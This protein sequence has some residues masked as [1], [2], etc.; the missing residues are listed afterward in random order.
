MAKF[1]STITLFFAALV[2]FAVL[3]APTMVKAQKLCE[4]RSGTWS[5]NCL[6]NKAWKDKCIGL[7]GA[8]HGSCNIAFPINKC[9]CYYTC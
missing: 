5:G 2:L 8:R 6:N 1:A 9:L 4:K 3:E 7:E